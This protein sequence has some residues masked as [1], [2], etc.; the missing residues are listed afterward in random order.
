[1]ITEGGTY[2]LGLS[3]SGASSWTITWGD[4]NVQTVQGNPTS[5]TH[6]YSDGPNKVT[7]SAT[8]VVS[9]NTKTSNALAVTVNAI[10]PTVSI[11][12]ASS[13][14]EGSVYTLTLSG[15]PDTVDADPITGWKVT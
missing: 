5:V 11:S 7:I 6:V 9:G 12:G 10:A 4:G 8:A 15:T 3:S 13:V 14:T 1:S 2:S